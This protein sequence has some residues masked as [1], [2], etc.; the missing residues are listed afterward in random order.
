MAKRKTYVARYE[1]DENNYWSVVAEVDTK[2]SAISD[3]QT[4]PKARRRIRQALALLLEVKAESFDMVDD[5]VLPK[6]VRSALKALAAADAA[7]SERQAALYAAQEKAA[8]ALVL[9]GLSRRDAGE[10]LGLT[11]QRVQQVLQQAGVKK[12]K[13]LK[14]PSRLAS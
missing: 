6:P 10:V 14:Q 12:S 7:L 5:V 2:R 4:L 13:R 8:A 3:G 9:H 11:G 1:R